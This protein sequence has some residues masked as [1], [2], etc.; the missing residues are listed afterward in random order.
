MAPPLYVSYPSIPAVVCVILL[1]HLL[2]LQLRMHHIGQAP[3]PASVSPHLLT[4]PAGAEE[5]SGQRDKT[6]EQAGL[7]DSGHFQH[8][9]GVPSFG[10]SFG[11][12]SEVLGKQR[13]RCALANTRRA[14][15]LVYTSNLRPH[16]LVA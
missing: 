9:L 11:M 6:E 7:C 3:G 13:R 2:P 15:L 5:A 14:Q 16:T 4:L 8:T 10:M 1:L 12:S